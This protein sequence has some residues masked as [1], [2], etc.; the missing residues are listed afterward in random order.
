[1]LDDLRPR[2][3]FAQA[4]FIAGAQD[5]SRYASNAS[6]IGPLGRLHLR[7]TSR[8]LDRAILVRNHM[9]VMTKHKHRNLTALGYNADLFQNVIVHG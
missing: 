4:G 6:V 3:E 9:G 8:R 2:V 7:P 1:M 5:S